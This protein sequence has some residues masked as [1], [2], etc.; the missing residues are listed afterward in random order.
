MKLKQ[1]IPLQGKF[2]STSP[3]SGE[4]KLPG[5]LK[6]LKSQEVKKD[7]AAVP[8]ATHGSQEKS[9]SP[10]KSFNPGKLFH[11]G[12]DNICT[13]AGS[14]QQ[15]KAEDASRASIAQHLNPDQTPSSEELP[16]SEVEK[17]ENTDSDSN[18]L[19]KQ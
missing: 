8:A 14:D 4:A 19:K 5:F 13:G 17:G 18:P 6:F 2:T 15:A 3:T 16:S 10:S 7:A 12:K 11:F 9:Q 1:I